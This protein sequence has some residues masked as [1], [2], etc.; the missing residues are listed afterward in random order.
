M[1]LPKTNEPWSQD[2]QNRKHLYDARGNIVALAM[3]EQAA[4]RIV[5]AVNAVQKLPTAA[6][7]AGVI[8]ESLDSLLALHDL[9]VRPERA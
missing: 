1:P 4:E 8:D 7:T 3:T 6:L 9:R 5:A 2:D